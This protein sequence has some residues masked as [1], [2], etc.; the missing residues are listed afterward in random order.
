MDTLKKT[1][2]RVRGRNGPQM[3]VAPFSLIALE[4]PDIFKMYEVEP[5]Q[6]ENFLLCDTGPGLDRILI[7]GRQRGIEVCNI[8]GLQL[9]YKFHFISKS[10]K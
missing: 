6:M 1:V 5:G 10:E 9:F 2:R 3:P 4:I 7:F 8:K